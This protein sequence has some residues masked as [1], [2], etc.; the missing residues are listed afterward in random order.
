VRNG[1]DKVLRFLPLVLFVVAMVAIA[2]EIRMAV[3]ENEKDIAEVRA[4]QQRVEDA[5]KKQAEV[6]G[7]ID[8]RTINIQNQLNLIIREL[9]SR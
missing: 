4:Q 1:I 9:R 5:I 8:E 6:N 2:A 3:A 7:R